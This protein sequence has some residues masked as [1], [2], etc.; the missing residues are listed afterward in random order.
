MG[1]EGLT[2]LRKKGRCNLDVYLIFYPRVLT[3]SIL[4]N[5]MSKTPSSSP[6]STRASQTQRKVGGTLQRLQ[7][8]RYYGIFK[9]LIFKSIFI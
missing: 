6:I 4:A 2:Q 3:A 8:D 9:I 7:E 5:G 1:A